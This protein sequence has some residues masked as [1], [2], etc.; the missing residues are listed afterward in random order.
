MRHVFQSS[1]KITNRISCS[2]FFCNLKNTGFLS[3]KFFICKGWICFIKC[4]MTIN[5]N[6]TE[7]DINAPQFFNQFRNIFRMFDADP[8]FIIIQIFIHVNKPYIF[9][10]DIL[11][12]N[13]IYKIW[14]LSYRTYRTDK[15]CFFSLFVMFSDL[16]HH[17]NCHRMKYFCIVFHNN[18]RKLRSITH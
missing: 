15:Y 6:S 2:C 16:I 9:Q 1:I 13:H 3:K 5:S 10:A 7:T 12:I 8:F 4:Y 17:F 14:I 11:L 18:Y